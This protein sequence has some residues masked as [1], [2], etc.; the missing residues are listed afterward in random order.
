MTKLFPIGSDFDTLVLTESVN[1]QGTR[2]ASLFRVQKSL[3][4]EWV[5]TV[6]EGAAPGAANP[7]SAACQAVNTALTPPPAPAPPA[8]GRGGN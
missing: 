7:N 8:G 2:T 6:V 1:S 3:I 4:T 5:D